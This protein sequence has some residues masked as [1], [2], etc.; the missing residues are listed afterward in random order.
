MWWG[1]GPAQNVAGGF[2]RPDAVQCLLRFPQ[3]EAYGVMRRHAVS[4]LV[5][6]STLAVSVTLLE[7]RSRASVACFDTE[8]VDLGHQNRTWTPHVLGN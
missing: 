5:L 8:D 7:R 2:S 3:L 6:E 4:L 1:F